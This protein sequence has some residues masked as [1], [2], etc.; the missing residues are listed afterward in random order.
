MGRNEKG[1]TLVELI[2]VI[3]ILGMF[4]AIG[5]SAMTSARRDI[6]LAT[7]TAELRALF[8]R[9]RLTA[10]THDRNVAI[11]F[12]PAGALWS[13][14]VYEDGDGDG[15]LNDDIN[16][17]VDFALAPPRIFQYPPVHVGVPSSTVVDPMNGQPLALR[18]PVRFGNS[19]LCSFSR[20]GQATNGSVV[21]TDGDRATILRIDG[22]TA[23][24]SVLRWDGKKWTTGD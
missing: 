10:I 18:L 9:V 12:R 20:E 4:A 1:Q 15:V 19:Q 6:A 11:R 21:L 14:T 24:I 5:T 13:W 8:Q 22:Q 3:S 16:K 2:T 7:G 23:R 17:G